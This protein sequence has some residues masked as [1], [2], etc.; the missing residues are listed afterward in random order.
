MT[1]ETIDTSTST[2]HTILFTA[3]D[4]AGNSASTTRTVIV[5][6][7]SVVEIASE[8]VSSPEATASEAEPEPEFQATTT[9]EQI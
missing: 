7:G 1:P 8:P 5:G 4:N 3:T 2:T 9:P 6:E